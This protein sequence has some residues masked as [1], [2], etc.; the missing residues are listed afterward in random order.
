MKDRR[1]WDDASIEARKKRGLRSVPL[2]VLIPNLLTLFGLALGLTAIRFSFEDRV[3]LAVIAVVAAAVLDG[4]DGRV[5]RLLRGTSRFGAELDSLADFV[6]FGVAPALILYGSVLHAAR[7]LG[8]LAAL[9]FATAM[10]LRLARFNVALD[11]LS[12]PDWKKNFFTG[13]PAPAGAIT[14]ML[15]LYFL[16]LGFGDLPG[17]VPL[18][19]AYALVIAFLMVSE[20]PIYAG[21]TLGTSVTR[22]KVLF[23]FLAIVLFVTLV[24]NFTFV[25][26]AVMT[27]IYLALIPLSVRRYRSLDRAWNKTRLTDESVSGEKA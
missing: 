22:D 12:R 25:T 19:V 10:A 3:K 7:S 1:R 6:N 4:L 18:S 17:F 16:K 26:L 13:I 14:G 20:L 8:W 5:A 15:P 23:V 21:K 27:L 11:D 2:R 24:V 9:V